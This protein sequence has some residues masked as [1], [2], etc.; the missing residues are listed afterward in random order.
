MF[1]DFVW[2][3]RASRCRFAAAEGL[4]TGLQRRGLAHPARGK[5]DGFGMESCVTTWSD[6]ASI[7]KT[8]PS[9]PYGST[10]TFSGQVIGPDHG[11]KKNTKGLLPHRTDL[12]RCVDPD[13]MFRSSQFLGFSCLQQITGRGSK[14]VVRSAVETRRKR[15]AVCHG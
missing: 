12:V 5:G 8:N 7:L 1:G 4:G 11:A 3:V 15:L 14:L 13:P 9:S 6:G 10:A 2:P